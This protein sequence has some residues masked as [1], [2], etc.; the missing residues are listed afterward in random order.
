MSLNYSFQEERNAGY[1]VLAKLAVTCGGLIHGFYCIFVARGDKTI[2]IP[3]LDVVFKSNEKRMNFLESVSERKFFTH[4]Q[5]IGSDPDISKF[6]ITAV[7]A[8][9]F[10][11]TG[12][13]INFYVNTRV[14]Q[15]EP[16]F[17]KVYAVTNY[18]VMDIAGIRISNAPLFQIS[19]HHECGNQIVNLI[20]QGK[21]FINLKF[22]QT[23]S[24]AKHFL[25]QIGLALK[26]E[27]FPVNLPWIDRYHEQ[28]SHTSCVLCDC[29]L[30]PPT[31]FLTNSEGLW[32]NNCLG[33]FL[34]RVKVISGDNKFYFTDP[35]QKLHYL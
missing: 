28:V 12:V 3:E 35:F 13:E 17:H 2:D 7:I 33:E 32:H 30:T 6:E 22:K 34:I 20:R 24:T 11:S 18:L 29:N 4:I 27:L 14:S 21:T 1:N 5:P 19:N 10:K 25:N 9:T 15:T 26:A 31:L 8:E 23:H 16:P